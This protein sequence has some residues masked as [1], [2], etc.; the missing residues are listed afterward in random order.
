MVWVGA[1][2]TFVLSSAIDFSL[3]RSLIPL[4]CY[5][6]LGFSLGVC[7]RGA[8]RYAK[9]PPWSATV[10]PVALFSFAVIVI[11]ENI[12]LQGSALSGPSLLI[13]VFAFLVCALLA[14]LLS[15]CF[16]SGLIPFSPQGHFFLI[17]A[18][19]L[20]LFGVV[21]HGV[22]VGITPSLWLA[23][24]HILSCGA[25]MVLGLGLAVLA[26]RLASTS[27]VR[28]LALV[29]VC[30]TLAAA[31]VTQGPRVHT[32]LALAHYRNALPP[33]P[34]PHETGTP[35]PDIILIVADTLRK[36]RVSLYCTDNIRTPAMDSLAQEGQVFRNATTVAPW[37]L[38]SHASIFTGLYS[39]EHHAN[40][41]LG[42]DTIGHPLDGSAVTLAEI[43]RSQGYRTGAVVAN[44]SALSPYYNIQ[45]GF[46]FY[47]CRT[48]FPAL[49]VWGNVVFGLGHDPFR[50]LGT[51][52]IE[53]VP[54]LMPIIF[55][56][57]AQDRSRP[58]F[59]F[60]NFME[61]HGMEFIPRPVNRVIPY[62]LTSPARTD[63]AAQQIFHHELLSRKDKVREWYDREVEWFDLQFGRFLS[64]LK[65][66]DLY[67]P[68]WIV[69]LSDHGEML[70]EHDCFGHERGLYEEL[71]QVPLILKYP[72]QWGR[73][74]GTIDAHVELVD[75]MPEIL[76]ALGIDQPGHASGRPFRE[77]E[78]AHHAELYPF[79]QYRD[80]GYLVS[81]QEDRFKLVTSTR[82][83]PLLFDLLE[84]P[85]E[86]KDLSKELTAKRALLEDRVTDWLGSLKPLQRTEQ[87]GPM[88]ED[89]KRSLKSLGTSNNGRAGHN[90]HHAAERT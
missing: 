38:P 49:S 8:A 81:F 31:I 75:L 22:Y 67:D 21:E 9:I 71:L 36:D 10:V 62:S 25:G 51:N 50:L 78:A 77:A 35:R 6:T 56:W 33:A 54:E 86:T 40:N 65:A 52:Q 28:T 44:Y 59:L 32:R 70:G 17:T 72:A 82:T 64:E 89:V 46:E 30:V 58:F 74:P 60:I 24:V 1:I 4:A 84:D 79:P 16:R 61:P 12:V 14:V 43:L 34:Q 29:C 37:T 76:S 26:H 19:F 15:W 7:L 5:A 66:R 83:A 55:E 45:Q 42:G 68:S 90:R 88:P 87:K 41:S 57:I 69:F 85:R 53:T 3:L 13:L 27:V 73:R 80:D 48:L 11:K 39:S 63:P 47:Y 20:P 23:L 18:L 2:E